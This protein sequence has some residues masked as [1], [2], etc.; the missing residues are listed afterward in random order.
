MSD[1]T[2]LGAEKYVLLTTFTRDGRPKPT[3]VWIADLGDGTLGFTTASSS[4]KAKRIR[5]TPG[6]VVQPCDARGRVRDGTEPVQA[7]AELREGADVE[8]VQGAVARKYKLQYRAITLWGRLA[9]I[10]G[11]GSGTDTA[12]VI[13]PSR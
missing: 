8:A 2:A 3:P 10:L 9:R 6:V 11:R 5:N 7:T 13:S 1:L 4:W 12:V